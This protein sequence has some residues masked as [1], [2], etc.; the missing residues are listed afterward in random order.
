MNRMD[1]KRRSDYTG[2][3]KVCSFCKCVYVDV[4]NRKVFFCSEKCW[5]DSKKVKCTCKNCGINYVTT[6][7]RGVTFCSKKCDG[8]FRVG[9]KRP[10]KVGEAIS[11]GKLK[12]KQPANTR[13]IRK[14]AKYYRFRDA[15]FSRDEKTC[16]ICEKQ[17]TD[18][19]HI[20]EMSKDKTKHFDIENGV[21]LCKECHDIKV[22]KKERKWEMYFNNVLSLRNEY[23]SSQGLRFSL[24]A[25]H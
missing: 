8:L 11:K 1:T 20:I 12:G 3:Q 4:P 9:K 15:I 21:T 14:T 13:V 24:A 7:T 19:H 22:S 25:R 16:Q 5:R 23:L 18:V 6:R 2:I 10:A 17:G